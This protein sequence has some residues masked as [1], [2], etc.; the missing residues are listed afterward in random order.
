MKTYEYK[1]YLIG[2]DRYQW[3]FEAY[4]IP[5]AGETIRQ[6][7]IGYTKAE[8]LAAMREL[9]RSQSAKS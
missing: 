8:M 1:G 2:L 9:I 6:K 7:F 5:D 3:G 4:A